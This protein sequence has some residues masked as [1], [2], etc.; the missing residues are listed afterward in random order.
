MGQTIPL[1]ERIPKP[2]KEQKKLFDEWG[3]KLILEN[4]ENGEVKKSRYQRYTLPE[5]WK[6]VDASWRQDLPCFHI[7]DD[8]SMIRATCSGSWKGA[9]DN[10]IRLR[11]YK[12]KDWELYVKPIKDEIV[13]SEFSDQNI[14]GQFAEAMDP[15]K[16]PYEKTVTVTREDEYMPREEK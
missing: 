7:V 3:I 4:S 16:R 8:N 11:V 1:P 6:M 13:A 12:E 5:G 2:T 10:E 15:L 14:L 9:Y